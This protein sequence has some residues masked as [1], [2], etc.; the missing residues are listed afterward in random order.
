MTD[1]DT[2][3]RALHA[4]AKPE[5]PPEP[6]FDPAAIIARGR[7]L[8]WRRRAA[9]A[10]GGLCLGV[11]VLGAVVGIG[12][13]TA[14]S[15]PGHPTISPVGPAGVGTSARPRPVPSPVRK[16][17]AP[18][19]GAST[20]PSA[21]PTTP[22]S[23]TPTPSPTARSATAS[24]QP[25]ATTPAGSPTASATAGSADGVATTTPTAAVTS[26]SVNAP[27]ATPTATR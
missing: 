13:L 7:R 4:S 6:T 27:S 25:A 16:G 9:A 5:A 1:L 18:L 22:A 23:A 2:L 14:P 11:A 15:P 26:A 17:R 24:D 3:R 8:R 19:E 21:L 12:R 20:S 10:G